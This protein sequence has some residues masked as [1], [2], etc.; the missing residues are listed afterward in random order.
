[1]PNI[2]RKFKINLSGS[3]DK[4]TIY[5]N[6]KIVKSKDIAQS[7]IPVPYD[8]TYQLKVFDEGVLTDIV[9]FTLIS[10]SL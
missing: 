10:K 1:M 8:G 7:K 5:L 6:E 9:T 4:L 3:G 2:N